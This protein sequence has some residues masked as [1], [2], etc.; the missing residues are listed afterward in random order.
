MMS[1]AQRGWAEVRE[2]MEVAETYS[3]VIDVGDYPGGYQSVSPQALANQ[4]CQMCGGDLE[5]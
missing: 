2:R 1:S 5:G 4:G 3:H